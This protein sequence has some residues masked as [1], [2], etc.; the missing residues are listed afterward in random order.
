MHTKSKIQLIREQ[1]EI[2]G[3]FRDGLQSLMEK[4]NIEDSVFVYRG[5]V[6]EATQGYFEVIKS[7]DNLADA[8]RECMVDMAN[9]GIRIEN[10]RKFTAGYTRKT[11]QECSHESSIMDIKTL[12]DVR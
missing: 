5:Q 7:Y 2:A 10:N 1:F 12:F 3:M 8:V 4:Y 11:L 9:T 6:Y